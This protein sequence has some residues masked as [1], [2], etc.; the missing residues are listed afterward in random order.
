[1]GTIIGLPDNSDTNSDMSPSPRAGTSLWHT[2]A[3]GA[4]ARS[5][6]DGHAY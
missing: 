4:V 1:M 3:E 2:A 6:F 5:L